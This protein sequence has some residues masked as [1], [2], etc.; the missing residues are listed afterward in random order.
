[1]AK[2]VIAYPGGKWRFWEYIRDYIPRDIKEWR[3]PFFGGGSMGLSI[4]DDPEFKVEKFVVGDLAPEIW[5]FWV[6]IRDYGE[7]VKKLVVDIF[8]RVCPTQIEVRAMNKNDSAYEKKREIAEE[9]AK[10]LWDWTQTVDCNILGLA[11]R[12]ARIYL[13]NR[14]SFSGCGDSGTLS[15]DR[16]FRCNFNLIDRITDAQKLLQKMEILN[17]DFETTLEGVDKDKGFVFL[18][19]PYFAQTS[20]G[21]YGKEGD[22]HKGFPH[23]RFA[24][25]VKKLP[26]RWFITYDDSIKVRK[27]FSGYYI[28]PFKLPGGYRMAM[29]NSEDALA[30]EELFISNYELNKQE[31]DLMSLL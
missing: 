29:R 10:R 13:V 19:P 3:E 2:P 16:F 30:G 12:A 14:I 26:C 11:G 8:N 23:D 5:A 17:C 22:T 7:E 18:D 25:V 20:S 9:E 4:A 21:L 24:E 6:G 31:E 15:I 28:E 27:M 1:M